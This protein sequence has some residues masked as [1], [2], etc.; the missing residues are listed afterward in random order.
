MSDRIA[1]IALDFDGVL[2]H[3]FAGP[4]KDDEYDPTIGN[5]GY[6]KLLESRFPRNTEKIEYMEPDGQLFDRVHHLCELM[7]LL[8]DAKIV[9]ATT[10][11]NSIPFRHLKT[12]LPQSI[13]ERVVGKLEASNLEGKRDGIRGDL[14]TEWLEDQGES[15]AVWI[16][17]D[18]Q[19][20]HY[21]R[22]KSHLVE[23]QWRGMNEITVRNA[24][25]KIRIFRV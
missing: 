18:D 13:R 6:I 19:A 11:R 3:Q 8:P 10:W 21:L 2:H 14:M 20:R 16:A 25:E 15:D 24:I 17:L 5:E 23:T 22:H 4:N 1:Y 12:F 7:K 9:L